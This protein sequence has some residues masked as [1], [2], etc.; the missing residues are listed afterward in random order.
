MLIAPSG[1]GK[2]VAAAQF[3]LHH[4][5]SIWI[6]ASDGS[7]PDG[8]TVAQETLRGLR[9][10]LPDCN[11]PHLDGL[12]TIHLADLLDAI[13]STAAEL[14]EESVCVVVD[15]V[16]SE[17]IGDVVL[18]ARRMGASLRKRA[19]FVFTAR[20]VVGARDEIVRNCA[21]LGADDLM[22][23]EREAAEFFESPSQS[24]EVALI[25]RA[26]VLRAEC[27]GHVALF[28]VL[29]RNPG[30]GVDGLR[31]SVTNTSLQLWLEHLIRSQLDER[32]MTLAAAMSLLKTGTCSDLRS[33]G[34]A[35]TDDDLH[36]ISA[37]LPLVAVDE[38]HQGRTEFVVHDSVVEFWM[39]HA[40]LSP[41]VGGPEMIRRS[42]PVL[43]A[44]KDLTRAALVLSRLGDVDMCVAW[45][46]ENGSALLDAS[47]SESLV[48]LLEF[49][50]LSALFAEPRLLLLSAA[51]AAQ[52]EQYDDAL[53]RSKAA[54]SLAEH[55]GDVE[56][57][58]E[59]ISRIV[60]CLCNLGQFDRA[61]VLSAELMRLPLDDMAHGTSASALLAFGIQAAAR[62]EFAES[63]RALCRVRNL[64]GRNG[65]DS[66]TGM[67]ACLFQSIIPGL[68]CGDFGQ[69][70]HQLAP[71]IDCEHL[72]LTDRLGARGNLAVCLCETGK[73]ER[74]RLILHQLLEQATVAGL[75]TISGCFLPSLGCVEAGLG[76]VDEGLGMLREGIRLSL[77]A[78]DEPS[79]Q[80][81]RIYLATV[82][83][84]SGAIEESL[85]HAERAFEHLSVVDVFRCRRL[86]AL[87]VSADF[88]ALGDVAT[89]S[90]WV[91]VASDEGFEGN[92]YHK[93]RA[94]MILAEIERMD[95]AGNSASRRLAEHVD[96][97]ASGNSSW[98]IAMYCRAFPQLLALIAEAVGVEKLP[99]HL[100]QM[101]PLEYAERALA[102]G[103]ACMSEATWR[104]LGLRLFD[105]EALRRLR[106]TDGLPVCHVR[107]FGGLEVSVDGRI[108][109]E[110]DWR[111]RK[112]RMLFAMLVIRRGQDV[113]RDQVIEHL[114][115]EMDEER[116]KNNLYVAWSTMKSV[117]GGEGSAGTKSP[118]VETAHGVCKAVSDTVHSDIDDLEE[119]LARARKAAADKNFDEALQAY[120]QVA[121]TYRGDLLPGDV[122]DDWFANIRAHYRSVYIDAM[123]QAAKILLAGG[124]GMSALAFA[125]RATQADEHREDLYQAQMRCEID[126][127]QRSS[128]IDTYF[129]CVR[130]LSEDLGIDPSAETRALY[131][132]ILAM[133]AKPRPY[134]L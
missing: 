4:R 88:L 60:H 10:A 24:H 87:E 96:Y 38:P 124:D 8:R 51:V 18:T 93:L 106:D 120:E 1:Y 46:L 83:R 58:V 76:R 102:S 12:E 115:P 101:I 123:Q 63:D 36:H 48:M 126:S 128:A 71:F 31:S 59:A 64:V 16:S 43:T 21:V 69:S 50:P 13:E 35:F 26:E 68:A 125:R 103:N 131:D 130:R 5:F 133:E 122:Y 61:S 97:I 111:K 65:M 92:R 119:A 40:N 94:D 134:D 100:L 7:I 80:V 45:L 62:G 104:A 116:A 9:L 27:R 84:A 90:V 30:I 112:A 129:R 37:I 118:Y 44:R 32:Q 75:K 108:I 28:S 81:N 107:M 55:M 34:V 127:C 95:G 82:L 15:D 85:M 99:G 105:D 11:P 98:Q 25:E 117:L 6:D 54:L 17:C 53:A 79:A 19:R 3:A 39:R 57:R 47:R 74:A 72:W 2:S 41:E 29:C 20:D 91:H 14:P 121:L 86:A 67:L 22:L 89:A 77:E 132:E 52:A 109:R 114:W 110:R 33:F 70:A 73:L 42:V 56:T 49:V 113:P 66:R 78:G 23:T